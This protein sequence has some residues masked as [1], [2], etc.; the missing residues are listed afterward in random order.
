MNAYRTYLE[1]QGL[2]TSTVNLR[3]SAIRKTIADY[4]EELREVRS[5]IQ[6][7]EEE[8]Q[9]KPA[10]GRGRAPGPGSRTSPKLTDS[11]K[12][13]NSTEVQTH[14]QQAQRHNWK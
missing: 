5:Q 2:S 12:V 6:D 7:L 14:A 4:R 8:N 1:G 11:S 9:N 10:Q 13:N 3:L